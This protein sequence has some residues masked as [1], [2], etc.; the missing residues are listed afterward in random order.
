MTQQINLYN[1]ALRKQ[2]EWLTLTN[3][4]V[5]A[6]GLALL[7]LGGGALLQ[8]RAAG[9]LAAAQLVE[10]R[11]VTLR[12]EVAQQASRLNVNPANDAPTKVLADLREQ[13]AMRREV[14]AA[15]EGGASLG[16]V[17]GQSVS[18]FGDYLRALAKQTVSDLWLTGF[19]VGAGGA[20]ME[21]RGR[22]LAVDRLPQYIRRLNEEPAFKGQKFESLN[23]VRSDRGVKAGSGTPHLTFVLTAVPAGGE[24][25]REG[26]QR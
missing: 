23:L 9:K 7:L 22:M 6:G 11:L 3:L 18:G 20:G 5:F 10:S 17:Q 19:T 21:V 1:P 26:D 4:A 14:L 16:A 24:L 15:L 25:K 12:V 8:T 13:L 2:H